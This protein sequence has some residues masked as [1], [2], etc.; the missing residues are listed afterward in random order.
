MN[1]NKSE[2]KKTSD[3]TTKP[4][5]KQDSEQEDSMDSRK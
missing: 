1:K 4:N 2:M 5:A 3:T